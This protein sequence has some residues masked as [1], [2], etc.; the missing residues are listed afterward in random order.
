M[1]SLESCFS[2]SIMSMDAI[3]MQVTPARQEAKA[4]VGGAEGVVA[5][6]DAT[7]IA[8][9]VVGAVIIQ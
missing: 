1:K 8:A 7:E 9:V 2:V 4:G 5:V 6:E 3:R